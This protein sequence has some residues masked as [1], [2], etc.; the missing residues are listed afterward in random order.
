MDMMDG[1]THPPPKDDRDVDEKAATE[2]ITDEPS[3]NEKETVSAAPVPV[4]VSPPKAEDDVVAKILQFLA[5][6]TPG[7]LGGVA[8]GLA[9]VT[10][11]ILGQLGLLLIGA[12]GGIVLFLT[13]EARNA[14]LSRAVR[15]EKGVD[16]LHRLLETRSQ[17]AAADT[18]AD[19]GDHHII[20]SFRDF[21]PET[22]DALLELVDAVIRD[23]VKW[24]Y[25]PIVPSDRSFP[26]SCQ[27]TL[28]SFILAV[29]NHLGRK[30]P[31][32]AFLDFLT[33]SSSIIIV[34]F[35]EISNAYAEVPSDSKASASEVI[36]NYLASNPESNLANLL[37]RRQQ[38][39]KFKMV[40]ED[41][42]GFLDRPMYDCDPARV[43][44]REILA[45][46]VL[47]MTLQSCSKPEWINS[48]IVYLLEAGEPD[49]NQ[50]ID[51]G[52]TTG[53]DLNVF[54]DID[55]NVGNIGLTKGNRNSF[56]IEKARRKEAQM[57]RK[58]LSKAEE[59]NEDALEEIKRL[60]QMIAEEDAKRAERA[61]AA[62]ASTASEL[63]A[64]A[65]KRN[66]NE[67]DMDEPRASSMEESVRPSQDF[68]DKSS[69][70]GVSSSGAS[71]KADAIDTPITPKSTMDTSSQR[72]SPKQAPQPQQQFTTFDQLV[73]PVSSDAASDVEVEKPKPPPLT[74]HN[75]TVT[76]HDE[77]GD[78]SRI[79]TKPNW[80]YL[81]QIEPASSHYPGWMIVRRYSD[82]EN[83]HEILRR[84]AAIS[85]ATAFV[86]QHS[87]LPAW[88]IHT[89]ASL[90]GELERYL[91]DACW[92]Q[93]LAESEGMKRFLE[94]EHGHT[95][96][97]SK[98]GFSLEF[99]GKGVLDVVDVIA[100]APKGVAEGGKVVVGGVQGVLG[101]IGLVQRKSTNS[102]PL[103]DQTSYSRLSISTPPRVDPSL[104]RKPRDSLDSQR[105]SVVSTQPP[106]IAPMDRR[107][108]YHSNGG[109]AD[110][111]GMRSSR[112]DRADRWDRGSLSA[113]NSRDNSRASS[114]APL[115]SP[116]TTS[117]DGL[118]MAS[119][120]ADMADDHDKSPI[121][122]LGKRSQSFPNGTTAS[123]VFGAPAPSQARPSR[124]HVPLSEPET[125]VAVELL[126]AVISELYT[127]S[128]AWAIRRTLLAA[129]KSFLLRPGN[130]SLASIQAMMQSSVLDAN[131]S[132]AGI[133]AHL[134]KL[135]ENT[136]PTDEERAA[137]PAGPSEEE[138][139]RLR[140]RARKLLIESGV[141]TALMSVMGASATSEAMG[142]VF[143]CL[144]LE[145]VARGLMF[146][147]MLQAV[148]IVT[149]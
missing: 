99:I 13:Y 141:P 61:R 33:N 105:S 74:L 21:R 47:E 121:A 132:D 109:E 71:S 22:R 9:F 133:A 117:L 54:S 12:F 84:I 31:A 119:V 131:T 57:H 93:P 51:V 52:M 122:G 103:Q 73:P 143:D 94:K 32:D 127:L 27:R 39:G 11:F 112:S 14:E 76:I 59:E 136:L 28:S 92:Y 107:A 72:S 113:R 82:F 24:W 45:S 30:R 36:H 5:T 2:A 130:P 35:S 40:A 85:G 3:Q 20:Q 66:A 139:E 78:K 19:D 29:S 140:V 108:S 144:Q 17:L 81:I 58:K 77:P 118:R 114:M 106:K 56:E 98:S 89:R 50:A 4:D 70:R 97:S 126:F 129:A 86:E 148:R 62:D 115:R 1:V 95:H 145:E 111:D 142:R 102:T 91:R 48:W 26:F 100:S 43:F 6:A 60:N 46:V 90:R 34:F 63:L 149:H 134:R 104:S 37:N 53:P 67:L 23:Y 49:F 75:A 68:S 116:S 15:G 64:D 80:D 135:R 55:G 120:P 7:Q 88:R 128:S 96:T 25:A 110:A 42:L 146:G 18:T 87:T 41:L 38:A 125:R 79:R 147:I 83:L 44:L 137:W 138:K 8:A 16:V 69:P 124:Q 10:Y 101:N 65:M 123:G